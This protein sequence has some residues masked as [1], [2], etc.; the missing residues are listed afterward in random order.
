M[1]KIFRK[2]GWILNPNDKVVNAIIKALQRT[3]G[4][5]PCANPGL[6]KEDRMCPCLEYRINDHCCCK[7]YIKQNDTNQ[8]IN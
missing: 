1:I 7:L 4:E 8:Q 2:E 6:L 5:C 3:E